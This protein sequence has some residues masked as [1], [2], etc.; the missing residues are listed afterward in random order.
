M[1]NIVLEKILEL[2]RG[3]LLSLEEYKKVAS[4]IELNPMATEEMIKSLKKVPEGEQTMDLIFA[5]KYEDSLNYRKYT[6][7]AY[8]SIVKQ[9][10]E[11]DVFIP[12]CYGHPNPETAHFDARNIVGSVIG[13]HLDTSEGIV[14]YRIIPDAS[15]QNA[16]IRRWLRNRQIN[17]LS[18]WGYGYTK[19]TQDGIEIIDDFI[20]LSVDL[21]PPLTEGQENVALVI[22]EKNRS[23][24]NKPSKANNKKHI[25]ESNNIR[26]DNMG[27]NDLS[28]QGISNSQLA[29]EMAFR[30]KEG[31]MKLKMA[32]AEMEGT[33]LA[34]E[35]DLNLKQYQVQE[36]QKEAEELLAKIKEA[37]FNDFEELLKFAVEAK[38]HEQETKESA[39]FE[40]IRNEIMEAKGLIKDGKATGAM[41][42]FVEKWAVLNK[43]MS[44]AEMEASIDKV[45]KDEHF[46]RLAGESVGAE[47]RLTGEAEQLGSEKE[48]EVY[49]I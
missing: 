25:S 1:E 30:L 34:S 10:L 45:I 32:I 15:E 23:L 44:R 13:A 40:K 3:T 21:V 27:H 22:S 49:T 11:T 26:S 43:G 17:A 24:A 41:A 9:I 2:P 18:I 48:T 29:G 7:N 38:K 4:R 35:E 31:Q 8:K 46:I 20:L 39:D 12:V 37:G 47:A 14:Y 36:L 33:G 16:D 42:G 6:D 28:L 5:I 19:D